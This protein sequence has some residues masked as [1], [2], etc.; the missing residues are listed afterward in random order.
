[1]SG[2]DPKV[3]V[4]CLSIKRGISPK[5]QPQQRFHPEL[6]PEIKKE[7]NKLIEV[8]F[9]REVKYPTWIANISLS[10]RKM[11]NFV[12]VWTSGISTMLVQKMISSC[13][14]QNLWSTQP[15]G[16]KRYHSWIIPQDTIR[17][18][19]RQK[20]KRPQLSAHLKAFFAISWCPSDLR[21]Q[22]QLT[23]GQ[24]KYPP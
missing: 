1:M 15:Q 20:I 7:V 8:G 14:S 17:F 11:G 13:L 24:C 21:M 9:I 12:C 22:E 18:W 16:M 19:W 4:H 23:K 10:G 2:L 3:A 5:K 6:V